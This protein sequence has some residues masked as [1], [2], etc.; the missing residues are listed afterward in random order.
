MNESKKY[1][2]TYDVVK[3]TTILQNRVYT[4]KSVKDARDQFD[5]K[6]VKATINLLSQKGQDA[7]FEFK[8]IEIKEVSTL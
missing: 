7:E 8:N 6:G 2:V 5:D 3:K 1:L 4:A